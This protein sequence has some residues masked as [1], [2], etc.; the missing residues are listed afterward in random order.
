M[1][2][3]SDNLATLVDDMLQD[4]G[5][6]QDAELR[7]ALLSLGTMA[8]LQAPAPTG[9]LAA[10]LAAGAPSPAEEPGP[11]AGHPGGQAN[12]QPDG[13]ELARRRRRR[14]RPTA[15]GLVL[16][17]GMGLGVG[18]VAAS[19]AT[20]G[21]SA[22]ERLMEEW[23]PWSRPAPNHSAVGDGSV[24]ANPDYRS[25]QAAAD[26]I[27]LE[28]GGFAPTA[29]PGEAGD[30]ANLASRLLPNRARMPGRAN[31]PPCAGPVRHGADTALVKCAGWTG[32]GGATG[33]APLGNGAGSGKDAAGT[34]GAEGTPATPRLPGEG[35]AELPASNPP[36]E[37]A[38]TPGAGAQKP[39][40]S[41]G[42][43][44]QMPAQGGS[45]GNA[46]KGAPPA[47]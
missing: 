31:L 21:G 40:G 3:A 13:D 32:A 1:T 33:A 18:G 41:T 24:A 19:T 5:C 27:T 38:G 45:S 16:V 47:K 46:Q 11:A 4:A 12:G 15:L 28:N 37:D 9:E 42:N 39:P 26:G 7:G 14:H 34:A 44:G 8:S 17:A 20:P 36:A 30:A 23:V 29:A 35:K 10:L 22:I 6:G 25:P 43:A 2:S